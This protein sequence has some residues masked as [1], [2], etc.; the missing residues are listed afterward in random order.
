M[1]SK[2]LY[3]KN[4]NI[5]TKVAQ[6]P[7]SEIFTSRCANKTI[8]LF[9]KILY[10][11]EKIDKTIERSELVLKK[12]SDIDSTISPSL[13]RKK[14]KNTNIDALELKEGDPNDNNHRFCHK[15][16]FLGLK[17]NFEKFNNVFLRCKINIFGEHHKKQQ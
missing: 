16:C 14:I 11:S 15:Q 3:D 1:N 2:G 12:S 6:I 7:K 13:S 10:L 5:S 9:E 17:E 4:L 8:N